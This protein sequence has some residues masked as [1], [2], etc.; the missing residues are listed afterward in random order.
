MLYQELPRIDSTPLDGWARWL[1]PAL[2]VA[3]AATAAVVLL[4]LGSW[5]FAGVAAAA[6]AIGAAISLGRSSPIAAP[7]EPLLVGPDYTLVGSALSLSRDPVALTGGDGSL[8]VVNSAY[9][10]RFGSSPP[11]DLAANDDALQ[12]LKL[13]QTMN[14]RTATVPSKPAALSDSSVGRGRP[15]PAMPIPTDCRRIPN[16]E[17]WSV[18]T[19]DSLVRRDAA[20]TRNRK[21]TKDS[22]MKVATCSGLIGTVKNMDVDLLLVCYSVNTPK[23]RDL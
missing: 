20:L 14:R 15:S 8:L 22:P 7:S 13:A 5:I 11:L 10:E 9:R 16:C 19:P 3:A 1:A 23:L 12:G 6:G 18:L 21:N 4:L 17:R 2:I